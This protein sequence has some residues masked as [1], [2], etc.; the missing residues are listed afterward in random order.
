[1]ANLTL[2]KQWQESETAS[3][4]CFSTDRPIRYKA[5]QYAHMRL[6]SILLSGKSTREFSFAS[7]PDDSNIR[8][9]V[10]TDSHSAFKEK[11][12]SLKKGDTV[13][14]S[15]IK[16]DMVIPDIAQG[17]YIFIAGG[18]GM[19]PFQSLLR[20]IE[21]RN[22][23]VT[24]IL[25]QID[26]GPYLYEEEFR[27]KPFEQYR[28]GRSDIDETLRKVIPAHTDSVYCIAGSPGF[29]HDIS[30]KLQSC[31]ISRAQVLTDEFKGLK[32]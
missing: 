14:L 1:M 30:H 19:A 17:T 11:L 5:G 18:V 2:E 24:P 23:P 27:D 21:I 25:V 32:Y 15:H 12:L 6:P 13:R 31:G 26:H 3:T 8:F 7:A 16:G 22:L 20:D 29:V 9:T 10:S 4:F 28:I